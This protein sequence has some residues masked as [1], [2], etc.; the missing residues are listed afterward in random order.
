MRDPEVS[1]ELARHLKDH[2]LVSPG[3]EPTVAPEVGQ[4]PQ[5]RQDGVVRR[6]VREVVDLL[7]A[8][9][10]SRRPTAQ[11][12]PCGSQQQRMQ[13]SERALAVGGM[14]TEAPD[15]FGRLG[16]ERTLC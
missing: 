12:G 10:C 11:L 4:S 5:Y 6:L 1:T 13:P 7:A 14:V 3:R 15:P 16:I 9:T 8:E 2:E